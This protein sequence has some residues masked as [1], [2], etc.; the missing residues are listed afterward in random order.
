MHEISSSTTKDSVKAYEATCN[1]FE[2][3]FR[4]IKEISKKKPE[5]VVSAF[6]VKHVNRLLADIKDFL[7]DELEVKYLDLFEEETMPQV[8]DIVLV[9]SQYEGAL[10]AFHER[11]YGWDGFNHGW[12]IKG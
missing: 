8:S 2:S 11:Y 1:V 3:L 5:T 12:S 4:E 9:M 10:K 7:S 6:K